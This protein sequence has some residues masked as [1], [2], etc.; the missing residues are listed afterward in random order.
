MSV[1]SNQVKDVLLKALKNFATED[2]T[3]LCNPSEVTIIIGISDKTVEEPTPEYP[4]KRTKGEP[5][6]RVIKQG[7]P[8]MRTRKIKA[9]PGQAITDEV[10][11]LQVIHAKMD[12]FQQEA[13]SKP[14]LMDGAARFTQELNTSLLNNP[15]FKAY[16]EQT[17]AT[18]GEGKSEEEKKAIEVQCINE[19]QYETH[20]IEL[21][22]TA[23]AQNNA[24]G[25]PVDLA[26]F[27]Y[28]KGEFVRQLSFSK[29]IFQV[30]E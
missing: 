19:N 11:F 25:K 26:A 22:I 2:K 17:V 20:D 30:E 12:F 1:V 28:G 29:D 8:Y 15:D 21:W 6:Y 13:L 14:F 5:Y 27:L 4:I 24:D 7:K 9:H 23:P 16:L 10:S 18:Q 3:C